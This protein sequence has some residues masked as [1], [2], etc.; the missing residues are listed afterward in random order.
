MEQVAS[1]RRLLDLMDA[2]ADDR[3]PVKGVTKGDLV[4]W[5]DE[6]DRLRALVRVEREACAKIA[7]EGAHYGT[8]PGAEDMAQTL[9][10]LIRARSE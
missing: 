8:A 10:R 5:F 7:D 2:G 1:V 4:L 9:A 3:H 6:I